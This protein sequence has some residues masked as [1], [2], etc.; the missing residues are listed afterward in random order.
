M[1]KRWRVQSHRDIS[2]GH[3]SRHGPSAGAKSRLDGDANFARHCQT[4]RRNDQEKITEYYACGEFDI[5]RRGIVM[6]TNDETA[7][8]LA[9]FEKR[10]TITA[11]KETEKQPQPEPTENQI[12]NEKTAESPLDLSEFNETA[13]TKKENVTQIVITNP[14]DLIL[15][16][17]EALEKLPAIPLYFPMS[18]SL[19]KPY[20][21]GFETN[22]LDAP[23]LKNVEIN[24]NWQGSSKK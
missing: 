16:E 8:M 9:I 6:P 1:H 19:I 10:Q 23:S 21:Q 18:Y 12:L 22:P 14:K 5:A 17:S 4:N 7:N 24:N 3:Q 20:I 13:E 15:T 2:I 11:P